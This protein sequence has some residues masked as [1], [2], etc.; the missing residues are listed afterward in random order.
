MIPSKPLAD[1]HENKHLTLNMIQSQLSIKQK[2]TRYNNK[3]E[4]NQFQTDGDY[5]NIDVTRT[6]DVKLCMGILYH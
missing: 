6:M 1:W 2:Q 3:I 4:K 5:K